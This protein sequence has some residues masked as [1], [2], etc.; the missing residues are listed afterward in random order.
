[1][2]M[3]E[4]KAV[5]VLRELDLS[6]NNLQDS[7]LKLLSAGL[8]NLHCSLEILSMC[9]CSVTRRY[10]CSGFSSEVKRLFTPERAGS[11]RIEGRELSRIAYDRSLTSDIFSKIKQFL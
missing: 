6:V 2:R 8:E 7:G 1:M 4:T 10:C 11:E 9:S 3:L 5:G